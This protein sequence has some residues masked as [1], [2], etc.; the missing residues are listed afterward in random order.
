LKNFSPFNAKNKIRRRML[1]RDGGVCFGHQ[2]SFEGGIPFEANYLTTCLYMDVYTSI[3][4]GWDE[5]PKSKILKKETMIFVP[6]IVETFFF[7]F[8]G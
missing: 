3:V 1:A 6:S 7:F 5:T 2:E 4:V 8:G